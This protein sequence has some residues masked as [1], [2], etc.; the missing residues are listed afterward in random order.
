M[1]KIL[2]VD[3]QM[4]IREVFKKQIELLENVGVLEAANGN[5]ALGK[6]RIVKPDL[7]LLDIVMPGK[8]GLAVLKEL[9]D[10]VETRDI[11]VIIISSHA[12]EEKI[13]AA[14]ACGAREFI[15][16]VQLNSIDFNGLVS[17]YLGM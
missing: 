15:D 14:K 7:I 10:D 9:H 5:E 11:P 17:K 12:D 2:I 13:S 4:F 6:I 8:D 3:D 16:K 1:K